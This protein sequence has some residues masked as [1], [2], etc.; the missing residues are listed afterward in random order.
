MLL[1]IRSQ[2]HLKKIRESGRYCCVEIHSDFHWV[3]SI[4]LTIYHED[5]H[6]DMIVSGCHE[7]LNDAVD[8]IWD[9]ISTLSPLP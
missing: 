3:W 7:D 8:D 5:N 9:Q 1:S 2:E 6:D 4:S